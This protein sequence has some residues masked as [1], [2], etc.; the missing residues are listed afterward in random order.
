MV[1]KEERVRLK[2]HLDLRNVFVGFYVFSFLVYI[3]FGLQ[4]AKASSY[5]VS[6]ELL[7]PSIDLVSEVT[8]LSL[9]NNELKTPDLIAGSYSKYENNVLL[10]GHSSTVFRELDE[11][12]YGDEIFYDENVY[13]IVDIETVLKD[14]IKMG[15]LLS[16]T[17]QKTLTIMTCAGEKVNGADATHRLI[18]TAVAVR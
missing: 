5:E 9:E 3:I 12:W 16:E 2:K 7:I 4:P 14:E 8:R 10:I 18:V 6:A 11:V 17:S 13:K 1:L 15:K